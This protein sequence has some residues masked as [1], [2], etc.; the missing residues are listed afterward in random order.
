[1]KSEDTCLVL[2]RK[3]SLA[4]TAVK[5]PITNSYTLETA[6]ESLRE[7]RGLYHSIPEKIRK[8]TGNVRKRMRDVR[9]E[10]VSYIDG[11]KLA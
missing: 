4:L 11:S 8:Y 5:L 10:I 7:A 1:M 2:T 9:E 6:R 3:I